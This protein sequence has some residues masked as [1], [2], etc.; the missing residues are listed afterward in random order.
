MVGAE[1][2]GLVPVSDDPYLAKLLALR[3]RERDVRGSSIA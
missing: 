1:E 3:V 2:L